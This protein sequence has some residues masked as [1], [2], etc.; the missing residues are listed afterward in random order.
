[1]CLTKRAA[2]ALAAALLACLCA[3]CGNKAYRDDAQLAASMDEYAYQTCDGGPDENGV[4]QA[5]TGFS[6]VDR[7]WTASAQ[8]DA[9]LEF[10]YSAQ[11]AKGRWKL[12]A[13]KPGG[14]VERV[15]ERDAKDGGAPAGEARGAIRLPKGDTAVCLAG[16]GA[17]GQIRLTVTGRDGV[18]LTA[19]FG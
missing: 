6:G 3:G 13:V 1:M 12:V 8:Q 2:L 15:F 10:S 14:Q 7:L 16:D 9:V 4:E 18:S 19:N 11:A 5:F 17:D